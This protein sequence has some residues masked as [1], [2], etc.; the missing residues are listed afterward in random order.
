MKSEKNSRI[1]VPVYKITRRHIPEDR[2]FDT[3]RISSLTKIMSLYYNVSRAFPLPS[4]SSSIPSFLPKLQIYA[5]RKASLNAL[6]IYLL[7][8]RDLNK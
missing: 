7:G 6:S 8:Y 1:L 5:V 2:N 3:L 4:P